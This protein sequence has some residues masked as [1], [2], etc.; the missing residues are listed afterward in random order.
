[1]QQVSRNEAGFAED[2][3][4]DSETKQSTTTSYTYWPDNRLK[5]IAD[6]SGITRYDYDAAGRLKTIQEPSTT[7]RSPSHGSVR[8]SV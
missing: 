5:T 7:A 8:F 3:R 4:S 1:M 6:D 2:T